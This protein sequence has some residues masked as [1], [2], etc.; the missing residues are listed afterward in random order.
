MSKIKTL[1]INNFK[2][3][4]CSKPLDLNG[5]HLLLYGENG[6]ESNSL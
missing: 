2:F 1:H 6:N 3:F 5:R 4:R